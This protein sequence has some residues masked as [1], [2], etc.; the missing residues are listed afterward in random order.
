MRL[1]A[2]AAALLLLVGCAGEASAH[3]SLAF[4]EPRDGVVLTQAPKTVQLRFN[5]SV[6]AGAVSLIDASGKLRSD[7]IVEAGGETIKITPPL[8]LPQ[9]TQI[10]SYRV[11]SADGHPVAGSI[12]FSIG[13]PTANRP[14]PQ[15]RAGIEGLIWL[16]RV[17]LYL[18]LFAGIGGV[19]FVNWIARERAASRVILVALVVGIISAVASL[20]LQGLDLLGLPLSGAFAS[21]PWKIALGTSLGPA[22]LLAIT[23]LL[24]G[25]AAS[26]V[27]P[28]LSRALSAL[29]L[30]GVGLSLAASGHAATAPPESLTRPAMFL[31]GTAVAFWLGA[32]LPLLAS[33]RGPQAA[34]P[35]VKRFSLAAIPV[36]GVLALTGLGLATI[37]LDSVAALVTTKYGIILSIKLALVAAL[38]GLAALNRFRL[39]PALAAAETA[40]TPLAR[41]ILL[42]CALA[43]GILGVVA[44]W[45]F[46]PPPR[47]LIADAPLAVHIHSDKAMFQ[48]L[49]S[50]GRVGLDDF[51]L[52]LMKFDGALLGAKEA[53]LTLSLP[54]RGI[55]EIE[56]Q[57]TLEPDGFWH[58]HAVPLAIAGRWHMRI[59]ALVTDFE[60]ITL[61]DDLDVATQ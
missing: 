7:A 17:G 42:E 23:A 27:V 34:L 13:Q 57:G 38:L 25:V 21:A 4:S 35:V 20:G 31:H 26:W 32:L 37:Q 36:V 24:A 33:L 52:Q 44:G 15:S 28:R 1:F 43:A 39:T 41:S 8:D 29:A 49:V 10:V 58:V 30:V 19:F 3:A 46:T 51:V 60:K 59:D 16:T 12:T 14:P 2:F 5:E 56:R 18:G 47:S 6:T 9:G 54:E 22:L 55:E 11:I 61:E 53:T 40:T 48:V 50:P 45:R